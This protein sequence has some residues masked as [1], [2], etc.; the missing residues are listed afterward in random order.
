MESIREGTRCVQVPC[1][2][3]P[4]KRLRESVQRDNK[5]WTIKTGR[6]CV[7]AW[8]E[9]GTK[10][11]EEQGNIQEKTHPVTVASR[12]PCVVCWARP[13]QLVSSYVN[14]SY[15]WCCDCAWV[16]GAWLCGALGT[17]TVEGDMPCPWNP[18]GYWYGVT[19]TAWVAKFEGCW[20]CWWCW[21]WCANGSQRRGDWSWRILPRVTF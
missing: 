5:G 10:W 11:N 14:V 19:P 3:G 12:T 20:R 18:G 6:A 1:G 2:E 9:E 7:C 15:P 4:L 17:F 16:G 13:C 21:W 8:T